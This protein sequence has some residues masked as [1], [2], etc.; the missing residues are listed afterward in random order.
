MKQGEEPECPICGA[1]EADEAFSKD[2]F[3][4]FH[5]RHC[6]ALYLFPAPTEPELTDYYIA[7]A[8]QTRSSQ[9]WERGDRHFR[10]YEPIWDK[11]LG[12]IESYAGRGPLLDVGCGGGQFLAF[13][14]QRGWEQLEGIEPSPPAATLARERAAAIVHSTDFLSSR[15]VAGRF[16]GITMWNVLEHSAT[17]RAFVEEV[18]RL[19]RPS[20]VF[21]ADCPNRYGVTMRLIGKRAFVVMPPEHATYFSHRSLRTLLESAGFGIQWIESNTI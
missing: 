5:C 20:G 17:P 8:D 14:S 11:A 6:Q 13:A 2:G 3:R 21:V 18:H 19:L 10:H 16:A 7:R 15:L 12:L 9:C 4:H 1:G